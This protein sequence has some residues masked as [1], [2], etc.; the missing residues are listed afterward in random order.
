MSTKLDSLHWGTNQI[1]MSTRS[2]I[3]FVKEGGVMSTVNY[4]G[5]FK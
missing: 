1:S 2:R 5:S 4:I 3:E